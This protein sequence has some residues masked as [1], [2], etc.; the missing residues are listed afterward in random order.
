MEIPLN[1]VL[2]QEVGVNSMQAIGHELGIHF[3]EE[4]FN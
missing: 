1:C 4:Y 3:H 2:S